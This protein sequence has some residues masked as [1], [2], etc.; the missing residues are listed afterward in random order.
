MVDFSGRK[1]ISSGDALC[2]PKPAELPVFVP[3]PVQPSERANVSPTL[4]APAL[5]ELV[6]ETSLTGDFPDKGVS[7]TVSEVTCQAP[8]RINL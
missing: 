1:M 3:L 8:M 6:P 7:P 5:A 2:H 4:Y